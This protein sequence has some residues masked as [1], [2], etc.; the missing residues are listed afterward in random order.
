MDH[1]LYIIRG[2][3]T[4]FPWVLPIIAA[5]FGAILASFTNCA[6]YRWAHGESVAGRPSKCDTC[7]RRLTA[8]DLIPIFSYLLLRGRCRTCGTQIGISSFV[9]EI[10]YAIIAAFCVW[11]CGFMMGGALFLCLFIVGL[12]LISRFWPL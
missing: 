4:Y 3:E 1:T 7:Q 6:R 10:S 8:L 11:Q 5:V 12:P 9:V 2:L